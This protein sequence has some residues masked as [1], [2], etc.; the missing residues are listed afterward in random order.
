G[1]VLRLAHQAGVPPLLGPH[2]TPREHG[3]RPPQRR[4]QPEL[5]ELLGRQRGA[6]I[7]LLGGD[8][9]LDMGPPPR[10]LPALA[11]PRLH[12]VPVLG[13]RPEVEGAVRR[14]LADQLAGLGR[15]Q[16]AGVHQRLEQSEPHRV[17]QRPHGPCIGGFE[18]VRGALGGWLGRPGTARW[19]PG[20]PP[21]GTR[22]TRLVV[23]S[24]GRH[25]SKHYARNS[26]FDK[27]LAGVCPTRPGAAGSTALPRRG[28]AH[29]SPTPAA[30][31][32][33]PVA[34]CDDEVMRITGAEPTALFAG[35]AAR[36]LQ[37]M[38]VTLLGGNRDAAP[39]RA[40]PV[41]VRVEGAGITT[42]D[43]LRID[44]PEPGATRTAEVPVTVAAPHGPG[45]VLPVT[46]I[47]EPPGTRAER[48]TVLTVAE[49]GW[50]IWMVS[51]FHYDPVW[52]N[53]QGQFTQSR[54]L[55]PGEDGTLPEVRTAF[56]LVKLHLDAARA[57]P[58]YKFVL[59]EIDY[60]K[61]YFDAHPE[62]RADL[63]A[64]MA[65]GRIEIVGGNY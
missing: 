22:R 7:L 25:V 36:P 40:S 44:G 3:A 14:A 17:G 63:R 26:A 57:D 54:L 46:A 50:T 24:I 16:R 41:V 2:L 60:L 47:A 56:E 28:P 20:H 51:H 10:P 27:G 53:T 29:P 52:W 42:P 15:G 49:P 11:A 5:A 33:P 6:G 43:P 23:R 35:T 1:D 30:R 48:E 37:I 45:S 21:G 8:M 58:D 39:G 61:P 19:R 55:L 9:Q 34:P 65:A 4:V 12:D 13:Q 38:R 59:A 62:D 31:H 18:L 64:L 32:V